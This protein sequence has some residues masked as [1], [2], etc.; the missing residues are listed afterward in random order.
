MKW[1]A[2]SA[3][4]IVILILLLTLAIKFIF[5]EDKGEQ[6]TEQLRLTEEREKQ[7]RINEE[8][9]HTA[10]LDVSLRQRFGAALPAIHTPV[11]PISGMNGEWVEVG[12]DSQV[13]LS[14]KEVQTEKS[15]P[16]LKDFNDTENHDS[17]DEQKPSRSVE[18]CLAI[19][20]SEVRSS[21]FAISNII[22]INF[23][24]SINIMKQK[25]VGGENMHRDSL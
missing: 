13:K 19:Y 9:M 8:N 21:I 22:V 10:A 3:D 5:F 7:E 15:I 23:Q 18:D 24:V 25:N 17:L 6:L 11:F 1:L 2:V 12:D 4:H 14:D 16:C 20:K